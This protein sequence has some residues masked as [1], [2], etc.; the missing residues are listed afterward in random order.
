MNWGRVTNVDSRLGRG[1]FVTPALGRFHDELE[2]LRFAVNQIKHELFRSV[3]AIKN[4]HTGW[5]TGVK[6]LEH[7]TRASFFCSTADENSVSL[8]DI[9]NFN[10]DER[11][12]RGKLIDH[13]LS[14]SET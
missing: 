2:L 11:P 13:L 12:L 4:L 5:A 10:D 1:D 8:G 6:V 9:L 7:V 14:I 3:S